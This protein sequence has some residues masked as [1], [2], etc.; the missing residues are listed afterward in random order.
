MAYH[1]A[2]VYRITFNV[3]AVCQCGSGCFV[4]PM[5]TEE[6]HVQRHA[7]FVHHCFAHQQASAIY[8]A[9]MLE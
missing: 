1:V 5:K 2:M 9:V 8:F 6:M 3:K 4:R 7:Q